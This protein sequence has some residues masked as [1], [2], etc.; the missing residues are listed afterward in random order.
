MALNK[1]SLE[2]A[3]KSALNQLD[4]KTSSQSVA[5]IN[6][7]IAKDLADAIHNYVSQAQ[8]APGIPVSAPPPTGI[9]A[10]TAPGTLI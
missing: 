3:I 7:K 9:G 6:A 4:T 1:S 8:V 5:D 10:T 2:S